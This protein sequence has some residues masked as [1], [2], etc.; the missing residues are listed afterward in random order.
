MLGV[1]ITVVGW[2]FISWQGHL[3]GFLAGAAAAAIIAYAPKAHRVP[4]PVDRL[5]LCWPSCC[6]RSPSSAPSPSPEP[7]RARHGPRPP[8]Y[9]AVAGAR[10]PRRGYPQVCTQLWITTGV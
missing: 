10:R 2:R 9:D 8:S 5:A 7:A 3:G 4:R 6:W 1:V